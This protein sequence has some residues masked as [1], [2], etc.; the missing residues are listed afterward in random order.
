MLPIAA[1]L[2]AALPGLTD[3][4]N[5]GIDD[6]IE[7]AKGLAADCQGNG[8]ID[9]CERGGITPRGYWRLEEPGGTTIAWK[10]CC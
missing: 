6:A 3:C 1:C 5:N 10:A 9:D 7:I 4:N 2:L 8:Y